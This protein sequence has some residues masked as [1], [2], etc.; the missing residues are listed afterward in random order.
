MARITSRTSVVSSSAARF[1]DEID[2]LVG[3]PLATDSRFIDLLEATP[4]PH[5]AAL[6]LLRVLE[7]AGESAPQFL[8]AIR[9]GAGEDSG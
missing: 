9:S 5:A 6:G 2:E 4:D 8:S 7:A 1:L 3:E